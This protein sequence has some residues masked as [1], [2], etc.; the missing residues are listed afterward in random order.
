MLDIVS[1]YGIEDPVETK[2]RINHNGG[3]VPPGILEAKS[4][5]QK[6]MLCIWIHQTPVHDNVPDT[7]V[8]AVDSCPEDEQRSQLFAFVV[9]P[10][11]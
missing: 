10:Q 6:R 3:V 7:A 9:T 8:N 11:T 2:D 5:S 1:K 4:V